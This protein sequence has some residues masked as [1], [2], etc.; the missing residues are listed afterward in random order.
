MKRDIC[1]CGGFINGWAS[2]K[3]DEAILKDLVVCIDCD[4]NY[5]KK[6]DKLTPISKA[7]FRRITWNRRNVK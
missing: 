5:I 7:E 3:E 6:A 4:R 2:S 1:T